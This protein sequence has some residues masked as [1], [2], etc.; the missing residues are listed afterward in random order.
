V[1]GDMKNPFR[2]LPRVINSAMAVVI[3]GFVIMNI[4]LYIVLPMAMIRE[5]E[6][7]AVVRYY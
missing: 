5:R 6:T 7:V 1:A 2:D 3:F 4:A